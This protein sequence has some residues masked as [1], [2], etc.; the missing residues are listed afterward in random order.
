MLDIVL[1]GLCLRQFRNGKVVQGWQRACHALSKTKTG[2]PT[3]SDT[4]V[5]CI[6][7]RI[8]M[9]SELKWSDLLEPAWEWS[10]PC[11]TTCGLVNTCCSDSAP[12]HGKKNQL[13]PA[14]PPHPLSES[15]RRLKTQGVFLCLTACWSA[16]HK[17]PNHLK[18]SL[19]AQ[20]AL[21]KGVRGDCFSCFSLQML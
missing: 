19:G 10:L 2:V 14:P 21:Q 4:F 15:H 17:N 13:K 8:K 12:W 16:F 3:C 6:S 20:Q 5:I 1:I 9:A 18:S 11:F 7:R